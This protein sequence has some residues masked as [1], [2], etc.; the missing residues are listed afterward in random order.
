MDCRRGSLI[1]GSQAVPHPRRLSLGILLG[2]DTG[3]PNPCS[4]I[5]NFV[6][7]LGE[8]TAL[9]APRQTPYQKLGMIMLVD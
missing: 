7:M 3:I 5:D 4:T 8:P 6:G 1:R 2:S 9:F